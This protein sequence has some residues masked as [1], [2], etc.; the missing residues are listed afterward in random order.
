M[1]LVFNEV[2]RFQ[3][4]VA[5]IILTAVFMLTRDFYP[6]RVIHSFHSFHLCMT[7]GWQLLHPSSSLSIKSHT[8]IHT[9]TLLTRYSSLL[10]GTLAEVGG[11]RVRGA[12]GLQRWRTAETT[13]QLCA[14]HLQGWHLG[15]LGGQTNVN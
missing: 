14:D 5:T 10:L 3:R 2:W 6:E 11:S 12:G 15:K 7:L 9:P 4:V 13:E 1:K 8:H